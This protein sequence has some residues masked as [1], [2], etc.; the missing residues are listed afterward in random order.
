MTE[1]E[2]ENISDTIIDT[3]EMLR[4]EGFAE[5]KVINRKSPEGESFWTFCFSCDEFEVSQ[6]YHEESI[7]RA[8]YTEVFHALMSAYQDK[9]NEREDND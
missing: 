1:Q 6:T 9:F 4:D 2:R 8:K 5:G 7:L 3:V